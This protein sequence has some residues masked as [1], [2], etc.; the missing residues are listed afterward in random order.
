[1]VAISASREIAAPLSRVWQIISDIDN[2][3]VYW[4]G[5]KTV[6]NI[7]KSGNTIERE[8]TIAFRDSLCRQI[9]VLDPERSVDITITEGPMKGTKRVTLSPVGENTRIDAIWEIK[10]TGFLGV[11]SGM[12][13]KHI[14]E[15]TEEALERIAKAVE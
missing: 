8:V 2:E 3:P 12:V 13:K 10:L 1:M 15:G 5:T 4:H 6:K 7:K 9:V 11:F 14:A